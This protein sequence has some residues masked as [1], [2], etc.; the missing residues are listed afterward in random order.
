MTRFARGLAA[1]ALAALFAS[2]PAPA[3][4]DAAGVATLS[5]ERQ[6]TSYLIGMD[7]GK[8]LAS[9][10][11]DLTSP[12]SSARSRTRSPAASRWCPKRKWRS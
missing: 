2:A 9:V 8:S 10:A 1:L 3:R 6:Q 11:P 5:G 12:R 7:I 4:E